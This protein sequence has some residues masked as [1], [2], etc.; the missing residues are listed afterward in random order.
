MKKLIISLTALAV[1]AAFANAT[2]IYDCMSGVT[3][4]TTSTSNPGYLMGDGA[5]AIAPTANPTDHFEIT[6]I[7]FG[8]FVLGAQSFASGQLVAKIDVFSSYNPSAVAPTS[9]NGTLAGTAFYAFGAI[10]TTGN[11]AY[12][13]TGGALGTPIALPAGASTMGWT[14]GFYDGFTGAR[15]STVRAAFTTTVLPTV[16]TSPAG[17]YRDNDDNG[18]IDSTD[19]RFFSSSNPSDNMVI[20]FNGNDVSAPVPEPAS[21]AVLGLGALGMLRR[22][23][24]SK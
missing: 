12:A 5:T 21:L 22:R 13:I 18:I 16:G 6:S 4:Y 2:V 23:R 9:V 15:I 8:L 17:F 14:M 20:R 1:T 10:T 24:S 7:D 19:A 11:A 3:S